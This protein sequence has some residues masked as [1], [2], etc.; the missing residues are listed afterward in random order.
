MPTY[1]FQCPYCENEAEIVAPEPPKRVICG[2]CGF[3]GMTRVYQPTPI[4][5]TGSGF[6]KTDHQDKPKE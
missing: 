3:K 5:F 1:S 2:T 4:I 6:Y